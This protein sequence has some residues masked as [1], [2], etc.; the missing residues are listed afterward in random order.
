MAAQRNVGVPLSKRPRQSRMQETRAC[1]LCAAGMD[2]ASGSRIDR[3]RGGH[4][5]VPADALA[6]QSVK[7]VRER[8]GQA[9]ERGLSLRRARDGGFTDYPSRRVGSY[10]RDQEM[11][12]PWRVVIVL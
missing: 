6:S 9:V 8:A 3:M 12:A 7:H 10:S 1:L 2:H 4:D 5:N 11:R